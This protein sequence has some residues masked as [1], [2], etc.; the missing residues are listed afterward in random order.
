MRPRTRGDGVLSSWWC[1]VGCSEEIEFERISSRNEMNWICSILSIARV[2]IIQFRS[3]GAPNCQLL[4]W[5]PTYTYMDVFKCGFVKCLEWSVYVQPHSHDRICFNKSQR[6]NNI[7]NS[8]KGFLHIHHTAASSFLR[9]FNLQLVQVAY[10][11]N[12][13]GIVPEDAIW[14]IA[15]TAGNRNGCVREESWAQLCKTNIN[16][17]TNKQYWCVKLRDQYMERYSQLKTMTRFFLFADVFNRQVI[18]RLLFVFWT[19]STHRHNIWGKPN[20]K[21]KASHSNGSNYDTD[22]GPVN[23]SLKLNSIR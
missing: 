15:R 11:I 14:R 22:D 16:G 4:F 18:N 9:N 1:G 23:P 13:C 10:I 19:S 8:F 5:I 6:P 7:H 20:A 2:S 17:I 12:R 3:G 21:T